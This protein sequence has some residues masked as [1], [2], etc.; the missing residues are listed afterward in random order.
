LKQHD[1]PGDRHR[2]A[3]KGD[4]EARCLA[5]SRIRKAIRCEVAGPETTV[6]RYTN[7]PSGGAVELWT[8]NGSPHVPGF[9]TEANTTVF[10][11]RVMDWLLAHPKP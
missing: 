4:R 5:R 8:I 1:E 6:L 10:A 2:K 3:T 7:C 11:A 9:T